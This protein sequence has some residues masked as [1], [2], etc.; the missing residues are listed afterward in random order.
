[1]CVTH[2]E[3]S[4]LYKCSEKRVRHKK[5]VFKNEYGL[6]NSMAFIVNKPYNKLLTAIQVL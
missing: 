1:M 5:L 6:I 4:T 3:Y 2:E